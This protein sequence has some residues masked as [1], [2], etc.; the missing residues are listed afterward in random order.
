MTKPQH[1]TGYSLIEVLVALLITT[2]GVMG[3]VAT[4][5]NAI[6]F[7]Q[8]ADVRSHATL[9]AY[10]IVDRMRA[11]RNAALSG[12][13]TIALSA[14]APST[15]PSTIAQIDIQDWFT[16]IGSRLTAGDGAIDKNGNVFTVTV[17]WDESRISR[18]READAN[19]GNTQSF[20]FTTEL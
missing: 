17:Q 8:T 18:S 1:S 16:A 14:D 10:E 4:H 9:L 20:V 15:T 13:Y 11:N 7:N 3:S 5:L 12:N 19:G 2:T 6:K